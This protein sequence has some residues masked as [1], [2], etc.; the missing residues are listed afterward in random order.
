MLN[1]ISNYS[2][3]QFLLSSLTISV[4]QYESVMENMNNCSDIESDIVHF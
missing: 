3:F 2:I 1:M 4:C